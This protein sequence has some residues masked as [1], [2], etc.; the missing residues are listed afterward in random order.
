[1][2]AVARGAVKAR[3]ALWG[4]GY[5]VTQ[6][7]EEFQRWVPRK[8]TPTP[9]SLDARL[10]AFGGWAGLLQPL[11]AASERDLALL[12]CVLFRSE[13]ALCCS[14]ARSEDKHKRPTVI[15]VSTSAPIDWDGDV[16][17]VVARSHALATRLVGAYAST[18]KGNPDHVGSQLKNGTFLADNEF[19]IDGEA[20][21]ADDWN[22][23]VRAVKE[24]S[25]ITGVA[26]PRLVGL[27]ANVLI[28][29]QHEAELA[30]TKAGI[31]GFYD[32]R[33]RAIRPL[34]NKLT[35]WVPRPVPAPAQPVAAAE[36]LLP[37]PPAAPAPN[38]DLAAINQ[39]LQ[40][41]NR[42]MT[43]MT[44]GV[45]EYMRRMQ[46]LILGDPKRRRR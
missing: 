28:G 22:D 4:K 23:I 6:D 44:E 35:R 30:P 5:R 34:T 25:G 37:A 45:F 8:W 14:F 24:W 16:A 1:M 3:V 2:S 38:P 41:L 39:S 11:Y 15:V 18:V 12:R 26:S 43:R 33:D 31:D 40:E 20:P 7:S 36:A 21:N 46:E 9:N 10:D 29:T 27:G 42:T 17:H 32:V 13:E 19:P